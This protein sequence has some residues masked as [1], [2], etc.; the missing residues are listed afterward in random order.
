MSYVQSGE[1]SL[2]NTMQYPFNNSAQTVALERSMP[3]C[4]YTVLTEVSGGLDDAGEIVVSGKALNGF[5]LAYTG[6]GAQVTVRYQV[7]GGNSY[8]DY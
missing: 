4:H 7:L 1:V 5:M 6:R 8:A 2:S 3:D